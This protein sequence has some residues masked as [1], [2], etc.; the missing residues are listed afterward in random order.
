MASNINPN[1]I[2]T[3]PVAGTDND[4]QTFRDN[5]NA[6]KVA[7]STAKAEITDLQSTTAKLGAPNNFSNNDQISPNLV[8]ATYASFNG[9]SKIVEDTDIN[10]LD[11]HYQLFQVGKDATFNLTNWPE[12]DNYAFL[13]VAVYGDSTSELGTG[14]IAEKCQRDVGYFI[15]AAEYDMALGTNYNAIFYGIAETNSV[16]LSVTVRN[17]IVAAQNEILALPEVYDV[18]ESRINAFFTEFFKIIDNDRTYASPIS[19]TNPS[20]ATTSRIAIK[21]KL[22]ANLD[23]I[24]AEINAFVYANYGNQASYTHDVSK[25]SRDVKYA[26]WSFCYDMLY[27]GNSATYYNARFFYYASA[28]FAPGIAPVHKTQT[29]AAYVRLKEIIGQ[30]VQG[31][32][33]NKSNGNTLNQSF[34]GNNAT[35]TDAATLQALCQTITNVVNN[36]VSAIPGQ[37]SI[38]YPSIDWVAVELRNAKNAIENAAS[39]IVNTVAGTNVVTINFASPNRQIRYD[40]AYPLDLKVSSS[41]KVKVIEFWSTTGSTIV[42]AKYLGE[43]DTVRYGSVDVGGGATFIGAL[44]DLSD[45]ITNTPAS[46]QTLRFNGTEFV[47]AYLNYEDISGRPSIPTD[48]SD[49]TNN[50]TA[51]QPP[52]IN[53]LGDFTTDDLPQGF[54][55][56]YLTREKFAEYFNEYNSQAISSI[57]D[58]VVTDSIQTTAAP[59]AVSGSVV[60]NI[61]QLTD[62]TRNYIDHY[63]EGMGLRIFGASA[64]TSLITSAPTLSSV[65]LSGDLGS[66]TDTFSYKIAQ[67]DITTGKISP[68]SAAQST[69]AFNLSLDLFNLTNNFTLSIVRS[70]LNYGVLVYRQTQTG[71]SYNLIAVLGPKDLGNALSSEWVDYY[72]FDANSWSKKSADKNEFVLSTGI[73]HFPID[74]S[75]LES[76]KRGWVDTVVTAVDVPNRRLTLA[77]GYYFDNS[78]V[79]SHDDTKIIQDAIN[80]RVNDNLNSL[81][82]GDKKYIVSS[83]VIPSGFSLFGRSKRS[84]L[85][86]L[87]WSSN[88]TNTNKIIKGLNNGSLDLVSVSDFKID[89]NMQNQFLIDDTDDEFS[90]YAI[91]IKGTNHNFENLIIT[92][93]IGG[94]LASLD[95]NNVVINLCQIEDAGLSDRY[96]YSPLVAANGTQLLVTNN[97]F[98]NHSD[99]IDISVT[100]VGVLNGNII[101][102]CGS[103]VLIYGSTKLITSPNMILGPAD[104]FIPGPDIFNSEY[105]AVNIRL[106]ENTEFISDSHVYQENG[107]AKDLD[108]NRAFITYR[109]DKL[110]KVNNVEELYP[111]VGGV[112]Q[113]VLM[114]TELTV[115]AFTTLSIL[116]SGTIGS[117]EVSVIGLAQD[118]VKGLAVS[119][120]YIPANTY[121][122]S[123]RSSIVEGQASPT[124][125]ITLS[126][127]LTHPSVTGSVTTTASFNANTAGSKAI[128]ISYSQGLVYGA[129]ITNPANP[130]FSVNVKEISG[131]VL[132]VD[133]LLGSDLST[134]TKL[135]ANVSPI[136]DVSANNLDIGE[137]RYNIPVTYVNAL[138]NNYSYSALHGDPVS[139]NATISGTVLTIPTGGLLVGKPKK[140]DVISGDGVAPGTTILSPKSIN[141]AGEG[142]YNIS[143]SQ[144]V[145]LSTTMSVD[146]DPNHVGLVYRAFLT[147]YVPSGTVASEPPVIL[148]TATG[149]TYYQVVISNPTNLSI[150]SR[151]RF[152]Y[153][154]GTPSLDEIIGTIVDSEPTAINTQTRYVIKYD[155]SNISAVG[156][157]GTTNNPAQIC[158]ENTFTLI[159]GRII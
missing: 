44:D 81:R 54:D 132:Y 5:Y 144:T 4:S 125:N 41:K 131:S 110:R 140:G 13:R 117:A 74:A 53:N 21:D 86:K 94:G 38:V 97:I 22:L 148:D 19:F 64:N 122:T 96:A 109:V 108:A 20:D 83:I 59:V 60:S 72:T 153:H 75:S 58:D 56:L 79:V 70:N 137:F 84:Q 104:E 106:E 8:G 52:Y 90:N 43:F 26:I 100:T 115:A 85:M 114:Q 49:L 51:L 146:R 37:N 25:C 88:N 66:G 102:N 143:I 68:V 48:L 65:N 29:V 128:R 7:L 78:L 158:I 134:N 118:V 91:D 3:F 101:K 1:I 33:V 157:Q 99:A 9:G 47:N 62:A 152:I 28:S 150:G 12:G 55:N 45:V 93:C 11:G 32:S 139:F 145:S 34:A 17:T 155:E 46:G 113:P 57:V 119:G 15:K 50:G 27:G 130:N 141:V 121:V 10:Y 95:P 63:R 24:E 89:G 39:T 40:K 133:K 6:I 23:F 18:S 73:V 16:D 112:N 154:G 135:Y 67:F 42:Y 35:A 136:F 151:V 120:T 76:A 105:D 92:N 69:S 147:Q 107:V 116:V 31:I 149:V 30:I 111:Q 126:A 127:K 129:N 138:K 77:T 159:K 124:Y 98:K 82:L 142:T 2:T 80:S 156:G 103:G 36:G 14:E 71:G 123:V 87:S 61:I